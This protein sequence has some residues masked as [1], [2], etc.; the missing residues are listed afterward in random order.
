MHVSF[1]VCLHAFRIF[2][3]IGISTFNTQI[4]ISPLQL[5]LHNSQTIISPLQ[6]LLHIHSNSHFTTSTIVSHS[7]FKTQT[8]ISALQLLLHIN[9]S[10]L[11]QSFHYFNYCF[12]FILQHSNSHFVASTLASFS[13]FNSQL[14]SSILLSGNSVTSCTLVYKGHITNV[15][16]WLQYKG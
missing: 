3:H 12:I 14:F 13:H 6:P 5:L 16:V 4:V 1:C 11:K 7:H 10:T 2:I 15:V 9:T 8:V